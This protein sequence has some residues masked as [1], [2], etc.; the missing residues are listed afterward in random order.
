MRTKRSPGIRIWHLAM[1][2]GAC[3]MGGCGSQGTHKAQAVAGEA[4][5]EEAAPKSG[6]TTVSADQVPV[7]VRQALQVKFPAAKAPEWKIKSQ[8]IYEA[9]FTLKGIE[10]T[11]ARVREAFGPNATIVSKAFLPPNSLIW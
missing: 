3:L 6:K 9:E 5:T 8:T 4:E 2:L 10:T 11:V 7:A 1:L